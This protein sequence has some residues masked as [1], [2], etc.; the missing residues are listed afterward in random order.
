MQGVQIGNETYYEAKEILKVVG[1]TRQTLWTWRK[2]GLIPA[3]NRFRN[4]IVFTGAEVRAISAYAA[5]LEPV[6][7]SESKNQLRLPLK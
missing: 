7:F 1:V 4:R 3:G 5:K 6:E 2:D